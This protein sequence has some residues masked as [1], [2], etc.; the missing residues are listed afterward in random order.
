MCI[1]ATADSDIAFDIPKPLAD[2]SSWMFVGLTE[3]VQSLK[4]EVLIQQ[5]K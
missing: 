2:S 3:P 5:E 4:Q 1:Q